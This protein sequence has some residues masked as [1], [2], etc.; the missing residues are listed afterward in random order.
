MIV[1]RQ[2]V[3]TQQNVI[4]Q[5]NLITRAAKCNNCY[6]LLTNGRCVKCN[7]T[8]AKCNNIFTNYLFVD[9]PFVSKM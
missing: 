2:N 1:T 6:I 4:L 7:K 9:H 3:I 8:A 5:Q